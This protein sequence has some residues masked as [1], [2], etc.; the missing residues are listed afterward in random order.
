ML[1]A[2][3]DISAQKSQIITEDMISASAKAVNMGC[4]DKS[5]CPM[6]FINNV[7]DWGIDDP[8][9]PRQIKKVRQIRDDMEQRVKEIAESLK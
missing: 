6:L 9:P 8:P 2:G 7:I 4:M 3:I 1:E 5:G